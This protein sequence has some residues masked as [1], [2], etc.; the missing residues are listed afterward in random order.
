MAA[1]RDTSLGTG[2]VAL[3]ER[4]GRCVAKLGEYIPDRLRL[5]DPRDS[6]QLAGSDS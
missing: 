2:T 5:C 1:L 6:I 3:G 4:D